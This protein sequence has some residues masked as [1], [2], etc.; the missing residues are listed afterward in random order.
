MRKS[1]RFAKPMTIAVAAFASCAVVSAS[2]RADDTRTVT[3]TTVDELT[4]AVTRANAGAI[5]TIILAKSGSPYVFADQRMAI[6][7]S[8]TWTAGTNLLALTVSGVTI[9]GEDE[10]PCGEWT[11]GSE[12]VI[13]NGNGKGRILN[14]ASGKTALVKNIVFTGGMTPKYGGAVLLAQGGKQANVTVTNCV[15]RGNSSLDSNGNGSAAAYVTL[16]DCIVTNNNKWA[17][18]DSYV[19]NSRFSGNNTATAYSWCYSCFFTGS[20]ATYL[21]RNPKAVSN[22]VVRAVN[23]LS[24][25]DYINAPSCPVV[26]CEFVDNSRSSYSM[27]SGTGVGSGMFSCTNCTFRNNGCRA[28]KNATNVYGCTF[29]G[30][31]VGGSGAALLIETASG[32]ITCKVEKCTFVRNSSTG[33]HGGAIY[34][35]RTTSYLSSAFVTN[36]TFEGN[37]AYNYGG[38]ICNADSCYPKKT[39]LNSSFPAGEDPWESFKVVDC[40]FVSNV[41]NN[42][43][44]VYGVKAENCTFTDN[45]PGITAHYWYFG[46]DAMRS[47]LQGCEMT[48][49]DIFESVVDRCRIHD[50]TNIGIKA[51]FGNRTYVTNTLVERCEGRALW[52]QGDYRSIEAEFVNCTFASNCLYTIRSDDDATVTNAVVFKNCLFYGNRTQDGTRTDL[53]VANTS[54]S[55]YIWRYVSF[56]CCSCSKLDPA[57]IS[58]FSV[59]DGV[60]LCEN[61]RFAGMNAQVMRRNPSEPYWALSYNS[62]LRGQ[63]R[64]AGWME[65]AYDLAGRPRLRDGKCDIGCY[66]CWLNPPGFNIIIR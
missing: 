23:L 47:H 3:V 24:D 59:P 8:A 10:T 25:V 13:V 40:T 50:A 18:C 16:R 6:D 11:D 61:P 15:F 48:G 51:V 21:I 9:K 26:D 17:V 41:A 43:S 28:V 12:P 64:V 49:G 39:P 65:G 29:E 54:S 62:P 58:D 14:V 63:G 44:G 55:K 7:A 32:A 46:I 37:S 42:A 19:Y 22:C 30:N 27:V 36:C 31:S 53:D 60:A 45:M 1:C 35:K 57:N 56:D 4:N 20:S 52:R 66:E 2:L 5:D 38:A 34:L 33:N